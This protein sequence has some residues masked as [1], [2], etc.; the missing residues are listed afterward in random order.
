MNSVG[1]LL[2][3]MLVLYCF[4]I[5]GFVA[6]KKRVLT[7]YTNGVLTQLTLYITLP[8]LILYSSN[9]SFSFTLLNH[10]FWL[11][12][13]SIYILTITVFLAKWLSRRS[14][15][16]K[17]QKSVYEGLI[18]FGNQ[19]FIGYAVCFILF[20][21]KGIIYLTI[22]NICYLVLIWTYGIYLFSGD[23]KTINWRSI[24][25]NPGI[26]ST[27]SG[28]IILFLPFS[29]PETL[30]RALESLGK[31]TIPLSMLLIGSLIAEVKTSDIIQLIRNSYL[32]ILTFIRLLF[33]PILLLPFAL[34]SLPFT[35]L[36][37]AVIVSGMPSAPTISFYAQKYEG[38]PIFASIGV[39]L[40]SFF[41]IVT[42]PLL[43]LI[44]HVFYELM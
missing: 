19:G 3:E 30:S 4:V 40:T 11:I 38:D 23:A 33:I 27:L 44:L 12:I 13:M 24:L 21:E 22:F 34:L 9:I 16:P 14:R 29:W 39:L 26:L 35:V 20:G 32:W 7:K 37:I 42:I 2:Q 43:Y 18:I 5:V 41:C 17:K 8:A 36:V 31:M 15:L 6:R 25:L 1:A 10:F 28:T